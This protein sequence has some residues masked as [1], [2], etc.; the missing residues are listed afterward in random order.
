MIADI[1]FVHEL[2]QADTVFLPM[3]PENMRMC[4][5]QDNIGD[6][7]VFFSSL[8]EAPAAHFQCP[9]WGQAGRR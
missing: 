8:P 9:Y 7:R 4:C 6:I 3:R 1:E 5:S 2:L